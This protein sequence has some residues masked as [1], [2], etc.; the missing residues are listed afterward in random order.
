M[1]WS[2]I[3]GEPMLAMRSFSSTFQVHFILYGGGGRE[4]AAP[5][6]GPRPWK[7]FGLGSSV[8]AQRKR[9]QPQRHRDTEKR[10]R[11]RQ[12][13]YSCPCDPGSLIARILILRGRNRRRS[14]RR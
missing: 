3:V 8:A 13:E 6:S 1:V 9:R 4:G 14:G 7:P 10:R 11:A 12:P 5:R 2:T